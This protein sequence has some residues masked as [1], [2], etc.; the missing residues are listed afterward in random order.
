MLESNTR[1]NVFHQ[2][3]RGKAPRLMQQLCMK[4]HPLIARADP[5]KPGSHVHAPGNHT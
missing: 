4:E 5:G 2:S 1:L 3:D